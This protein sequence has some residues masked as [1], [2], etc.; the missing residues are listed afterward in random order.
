MVDIGRDRRSLSALLL[1]A[2][3][4]RRIGPHDQA[5]VLAEQLGNAEI[6]QLDLG[7]ASNQHVGRLDIAMNQAACV[8]KGDRRANLDE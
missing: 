1:W 4:A 6:E 2:G 8:R 5:I 7:V 3:E